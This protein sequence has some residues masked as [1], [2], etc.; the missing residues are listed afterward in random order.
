MLRMV[1]A[2]SWR[3]RISNDILYR[4]L[5]KL[6]D[7]IRS[8]RLKLAGHCIFFCINDTK[9]IEKHSVIDTSTQE[10]NSE[11]VESNKSWHIPQPVVPM[12]S[13]RAFP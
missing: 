6:S 5:P 13:T 4:N 10:H 7:K 1:T 3:D 8:R 9:A 2:V 11:T 12:Y